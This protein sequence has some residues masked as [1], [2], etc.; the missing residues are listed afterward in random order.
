MAV[1]TY[2]VKNHI[3]Y[4]TLNRPD[5]LNCFNFDTLSVLQGIVDDIY[6]DRDVRAVIFMGSGERAFSAGADLKERRTL[7]ESE[8][9]RNVKKIREVF[10]AVESLPQPT[11]AAL[12]GYAFG[13]GF[14]LALACDF[15]YAVEG[16]KMGLTETSLG[17]IPGAGGTQRLPRLIGTAKAMELVLTARKLSSEEA[18]EYGILN[19]VVHREKLLATCEEL[20]TEICRNAPVAVQQAKFA[21]REGM[22]VD[23]H[24]GMAIE[25]KAYE[26]TIPT[27]DRIEALEAFS[28]KR[29][30]EFK[31]E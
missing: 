23:R 18:Y 25:S 8:V 1:V 20:A 27:K 13:G 4:V 10:T 26:V 30:P 2:E 14:E 7:T 17:I 29:K 9:R 22:N 5:V 24:T 6:S 15:R 3:G 16:T 19:G 21:V 28:E 31:G 11:I 12:N